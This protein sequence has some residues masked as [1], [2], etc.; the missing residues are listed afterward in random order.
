VWQSSRMLRLPNLR[1]QRTCSAPLRS[2][3]SRKP[4]GGEWAQVG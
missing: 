1:L 3:L 2:P 4:L